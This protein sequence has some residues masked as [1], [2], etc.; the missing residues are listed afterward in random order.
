MEWENKS[1]SRPTG[2][3]LAGLFLL[4]VGVVT[5]AVAIALTMTVGTV[6]APVFMVASILINTL[7]VIFLRKKK[8]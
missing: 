6:L 2:L 1:S 8:S 4:G 3:R 5:L 7:A